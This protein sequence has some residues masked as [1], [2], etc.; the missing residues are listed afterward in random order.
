MPEVAICIPARD[1]AGEL[2]GLFDALDRLD[3]GTAEAVHVCLLL[4]GCTDA[5]AI[6]AA[7]YGATSR[8]RVRIGRAAVAPANA[9]RA[10][11]RAMA[12]GLEVLTDGLLL[13]TDADSRPAPDWLAAMVAGLAQADLVAGRIVRRGDRPNRLQDRLEAYYDALFALRRRL[14]PVPWEAEV[15]HHHAGGANLGVRATAYRALG[16]FE[17]LPSGEDAR[18][19]DDAARAGLRVRRDAAC[20]VR[21]S[22]RRHGRAEHGLALSL[23]QLDDV[24]LA[25]IRVTHPDDAAWQYRMQ[26]IARAA[27]DEPRFGAVGA[28]IGLTADHV[29][30]VARDCPNAEAFAM[31]IV[32][33]PP[34]GMR[35]VGLPAAEVALGRLADARQA[36]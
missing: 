33:A 6:L 17:P 26:A 10:R 9:G 15:T 30:G 16:G 19:L 21:T 22:D 24:G 29:R 32:P 35:E 31:R 18:L 8:H 13:T 25:A 11:R 2:P 5:S 7:D 1:E 28:A 3:A 34:G 23:R 20:V 4:D 27:F 14:D 12:M 36:A